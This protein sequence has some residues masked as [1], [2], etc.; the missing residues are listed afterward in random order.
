LQHQTLLKP[1]NTTMPTTNVTVPTM[2]TNTPNE[3]RIVVEGGRRLVGTVPISGSKNAALGLMA[4][5]LLASVGTVTLTNLPHISDL[6]TMADLLRSVGAVVTFSDDNHTAT[7]DARNLNTFEPAANLS[8]QMRGSLHLLG[9]LLA[10]LNRVRNA[11][12]GGCQI[13]ARAVDQHIKAFKALGATVEESHGVI[14]AEGPHEGLVGASVVLDVA[15]VGA[16]MNLMMA[17]SLAQGTTIIE[18]AAQEPDVVDL[19]NLIVAMGGK[20]AGQGS[21][22]ITIVG[23]KELKGC[24]YRTMPDR[25][26]AGTYAMAAGITGGDLLLEGA[27]ADHVR[28]ILLKLSEVGM[29]IEELPQGIRVAHPGKQ[30][31]LKSTDVTTQTHPGFPTDLQQPFASLLALTDGTSVITE[32]V[33]EGRFRYLD[34]LRKMGAKSRS[35]DRTAII[36]GVESLSGADVDATDLRAGAAMVLAGL[37]AEGRTRVFKIHHIDRGY[38]RLVEK[39]TAVGAVIWREDEQGNRVDS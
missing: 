9:P 32:K 15:S 14:F 5:S 19:A 26:E 1:E 35:Q 13:G 10:R 24:R 29:I 22:M 2:N 21:G 18:N 17:A 33:Y 28:S 37:A 23:V 11:Q 8:A 31:R 27:N 25:I 3:P 38:E 12:P 6:E 20:I 34:E 16:T 4:G 7:I 36:T 39:L 30:I